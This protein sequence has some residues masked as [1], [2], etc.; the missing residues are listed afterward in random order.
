M[1]LEGPF[2]LLAV[3]NAEKC[4]RQLRCYREI[5]KYDAAVEKK[6]ENK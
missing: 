3:F 1:S 4:H 2:T 5:E 6:T